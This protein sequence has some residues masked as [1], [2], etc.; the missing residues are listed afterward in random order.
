RVYVQKMGV[1][2][3]ERLLADSPADQ[4]LNKRLVHALLMQAGSLSDP[5]SSHVGDT[6]GAKRA[7]ERAVE[8]AEALKIRDSRDRANTTLATQAY[9]Y[10]GKNLLE[11]GESKK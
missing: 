8:L 2:F 4:A 10:L 9:Y 1:E 6:A 11:R 7:I 3:L 5:T